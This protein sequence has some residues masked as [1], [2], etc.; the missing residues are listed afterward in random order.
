[1]GLNFYSFIGLRTTMT[2]KKPYETREIKYVIFWWQFQTPYRAEFDDEVAACA[3]AA[4]RNAMVVEVSGEKLRVD[5]AYDFYRRD[6]K[7]NPMPAELRDI[8]HSRLSAKYRELLG[9]TEQ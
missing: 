2:K 8:E 3:A 5:K 7:G 1:M 6:D 9:L 4:V